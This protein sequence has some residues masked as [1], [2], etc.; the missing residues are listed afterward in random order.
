MLQARQ[1]TIVRPK[2]Q[3]VRRNRSMRHTTS[4]LQHGCRLVH[5]PELGEC[6]GCRRGHEE[7][8]QEDEREAAERSPGDGTQQRDNARKVKVK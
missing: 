5:M 4:V 7:A 2:R 8:G 3:K 1:Q 6:H